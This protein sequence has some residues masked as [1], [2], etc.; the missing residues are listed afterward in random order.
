M[1]LR[2][3]NPMP[4]MLAILAIAIL[5]LSVTAEVTYGTHAVERHGSDATAVRC[6]VERGQT[7]FKMFNPETRRWALC[8]PVGEKWGVQILT[9]DLTREITA[10]VKNKMRHIE[11]VIRYL[12]NAGYK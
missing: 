4:F 11:D 1:T 2:L 10:I 5:W 3:S 9:E 6:A 7:V 12:G 8:V